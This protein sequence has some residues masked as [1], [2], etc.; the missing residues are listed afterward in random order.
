MASKL[1]LTFSKTA[2]EGDHAVICLVGAKGKLFPEL[3]KSFAAAVIAAMA[4]AQFTGDSGKSL[5]LYIGDRTVVLIGVG[6]PSRPV[7]RRKLSA[8][9]SCRLSARCSPSGLSSGP[10]RC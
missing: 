5:T 3:E 2:P 8:A 10:G 7:P 1:D 6:D 4:T 9:A